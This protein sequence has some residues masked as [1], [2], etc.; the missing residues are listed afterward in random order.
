M[1]PAEH[2]EWSLLVAMEIMLPSAE[3]AA[4]GQFMVIMAPIFL[5]S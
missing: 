1:V 4:C 5:D 2:Q 3:D